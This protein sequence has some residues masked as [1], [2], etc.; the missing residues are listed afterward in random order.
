MKLAANIWAYEQK[1]HT[2][3]GGAGDVA[4]ETK[5]L[6]CTEHYGVNAEAT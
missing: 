6:Y 1:L 4:K 5:A 2:R 3:R